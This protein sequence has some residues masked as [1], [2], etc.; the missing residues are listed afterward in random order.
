MC[1]IKNIITK[2]KGMFCSESSSCCSTNKVEVPKTSEIKPE[3]K[4]KMKEKPEIKK[5]KKVTKSEPSESNIKN[6][7]FLTEKKL[8]DAGVEKALEIIKKNK[9]EA[10]LLDKSGKKLIGGAYKNRLIK[11]LHENNYHY[12]N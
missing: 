11:V 6:D 5:E 7:Y 3:I 9:Q 1:F 4:V 2:I 8:T 10:L 12:S